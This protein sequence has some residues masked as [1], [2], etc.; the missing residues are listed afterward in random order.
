MQSGCISEVP[1]DL[2]TVVDPFRERIYRAGD[3]DRSES[4]AVVQDSVFGAVGADEIQQNLAVVVDPMGLG[5]PIEPGR[6][7]VVKL[8][9][10]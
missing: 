9:L 10:L 6:S 1:H 2:A 8:P 4:T 5:E 3:I 7:I